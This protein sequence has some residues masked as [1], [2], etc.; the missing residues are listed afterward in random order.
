MLQQDKNL[1]LIAKNIETKIIKELTSMM[2]EDKENYE[3]FFKTFG[4]TIKYG[5]Y[6]TL[7]CIKINYKI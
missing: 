7:V 2:K 3:K 6:E 5:I 4:A 1:K